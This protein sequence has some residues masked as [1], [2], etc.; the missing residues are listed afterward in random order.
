[1]GLGHMGQGRRTQGI[2]PEQGEGD[3]VEEKTDRQ[4][5]HNQYEHQARAVENYR[6][7]TESKQGSKAACSR[8]QDRYPGGSVLHTPLLLDLAARFRLSQPLIT[9]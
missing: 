1:M 6:R 3:L 7:R 2:H 8:Y 5:L 4:L 9:S